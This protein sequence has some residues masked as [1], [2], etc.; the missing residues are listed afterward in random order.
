MKQFA[1]FLLTILTQT[2]TAQYDYRGAEYF[3]HDE[4]VTIYLEA[5]K[6]SRKSNDKSQY[7]YRF[8][9]VDM[10]TETG[11]TEML[12]KELGTGENAKHNYK[13]GADFIAYTKKYIV[14]QGHT[15]F[16]IYDIRNKK[17]SPEYTPQFYGTKSDSLSGTLTDIVVSKNGEY[18]YGSHRD[19]G[20]FL[21]SVCDITHPFEYQSANIPVFTSARFYI[22]DNCENPELK[23]GFYISQYENQPIF[24]ELFSNKKLINYPT[25]KSSYTEEEIEDIILSADLA[26]QRYCIIEEST[27]K[28]LVIDLFVGQIRSLPEGQNFNSETEVRKYLVEADAKEKEAELQEGL[29]E[30]G[31]N[32]DNN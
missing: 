3:N 6:A 19:G 20:S 29:D 24:K 22:F 5:D 28:F 2:L 16:Y 9:K 11:I 27:N 23:N 26:N 25:T 32:P 8:L 14:I 21:Y 12:R 13:F 18:L 7:I 4:E 1:F 31:I 15:S 30:D 10:N 17:L